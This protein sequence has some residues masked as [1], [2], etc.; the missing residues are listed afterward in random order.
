MLIT[1][2]ITIIIVFSLNSLSKKYSMKGLNYTRDFPKNVVEIDEEFKIKTSIENKKFLPVTFLQVS[3]EYPGEIEYVGDIKVKRNVDKSEHVMYMTLMPHQRIKRTYRATVSKRGRYLIKDVTITVGDMMGFK[4]FSEDIFMIQEMIVLPKPYDI[5]NSFVPYGSYN[6]DISVRRWIIE[7]PILIV[8]LREYSGFEPQK[9]I[10]WPSSL[11]SGR[12]MVKKF[13]YTTDNR[14]MILLNIEAYKP[15][16]MHIDHIA[17]EKC[18]SIV[19]TLCE[20]FEMQGIPYGFATN[21]QIGGASGNSI[22]QTGWGNS[23]LSGILETLGRIDYGINMPFEELMKKFIENRSE[24]GTIIVVTP[25]VM[26]PYI[27]YV[28]N[29]KKNCQK[30][31]LLSLKEDNLNLLDDDIM[32]LIEG[33]DNE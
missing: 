25:S 14:V 15:F 30:L 4:V 32:T 27:E 2:I 33:R 18:I 11:K 28:N 1:V 10:H 23:H 13:D 16:W 22:Y 5:E 9:T 3:E 20:E 6:G 7:D 26:E 19:R 12:L 24:Y 29:I 17:I 31:V 21:S 8:G